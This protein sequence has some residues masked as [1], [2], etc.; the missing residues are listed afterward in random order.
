M[1]P[2]AAW[3]VKH[4]LPLLSWFVTLFIPGQNA[5]IAYREARNKSWIMSLVNNL[6]QGFP[7]LGTFEPML[8]LPRMVDRC[9]EMGDFPAVWG[10][11]GLGLYHVEACKSKHIPLKNILSVPPLDKL[12]LDSMTMLHAGIGLSAARGCLTGLTAG[13]PPA[14]LRKALE[15]FITICRDNSRPGYLGCAFESLG[16]VSLVLHNPDMARALDRELATLDPVVATFMWRGAGRAL[17]FHPAH[18]IPGIHCA[19]R[20]IAKSRAIAPHETARQ[21]LRAGVAWPTTIVNIRDP[22][23]MERVLLYQGENDPDRDLFVNG[24]MSSMVMRYDTSPNDP[25]IRPFIDHRPDP[26]NALLCR[27]WK[28]DIKEPIEM[29]INE[30]HPVLKANDA[31]D[32]VFHYQSLTD[33][34][35]RLKAGGKAGR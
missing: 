32:E 21:N 23:V 27:L 20:G 35:T 24:V 31:I 28:R 25:T 6:E 19:W 29:A 16:L 9:Y 12:R 10:V 26:G 5:R 4:V 33:L 1:P 18:F 30:V 34:V 11:E 13:S 7:P 17:Y 2:F 8:E 22:E 14:Q 15:Q 3:L